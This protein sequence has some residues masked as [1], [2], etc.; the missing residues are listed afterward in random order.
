MLLVLSVFVG[1][2]AAQSSSS[3]ISASISMSSAVANSLPMS[4]DMPMSAAPS[5]SDTS[6]NYTITALPAVRSQPSCVYNCLIPIGL[7]D[8]SGCDDVTDDCACLSAPADVLDA[9]TECANTVCKSSTSEY[10]A[11]ATSLYQSYC[12]SVYGSRSISQAFIAESSADAASSSAAAASNMSAS[13]MASSTAAMAT[14]SAAGATRS[15]SA[16]AKASFGSHTESE[17]FLFVNPPLGLF[18][19][20][21][22]L[23]LQVV[24]S[25]ACLSLAASSFCKH[26]E[27]RAKGV[28]STL[29]HLARTG[30]VKS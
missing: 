27:S 22:W 15:P 20:D 1:L 16:S 4:T 12:Q 5:S 28:S 10:G 21:F 18:E 24:H 2:A 19:E 29:S 17:S 26:C 6:P 3:T 14:A 25:L 13:M 11:S 8:P 9:L 23:M 30:G 7:A